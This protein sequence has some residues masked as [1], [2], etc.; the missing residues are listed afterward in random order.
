MRA[1]DVMTAAVVNSERA[2]RRFAAETLA[3]I[4][5]VEDHLMD[6]RTWSSVG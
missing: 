3:G 5:G 6:Y 2:A 1:G 4:R